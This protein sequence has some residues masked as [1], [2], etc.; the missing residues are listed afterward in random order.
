MTPRE[1]LLTV[2][3]ERDADDVIEHRRVTIKKPLTRRAAEILVREFVRFGDP[4]RAVE[5]MHEKAWQGFKAEWVH[6]RTISRTGNGLLDA[7][8]R[9]TVQ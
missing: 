4:A 2:L 5:I 1:V 9:V 3:S 7:L 6:E 8:G